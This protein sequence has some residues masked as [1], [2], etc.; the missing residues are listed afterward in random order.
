MQPKAPRRSGR[1]ALLVFVAIIA[2]LFLAVNALTT[3]YIER[4]LA[5]AAEATLARPVSYQSLSANGWT[6]TLSLEELALASVEHATAVGVGSVAADFDPLSLPRDRMRLPRV[7][8]QDVRLDLSRGADGARR[9]ASAFSPGAT[10]PAAP[11]RGLEAGSLRIVGVNL[12]DQY[13]GSEGA[14]L[15]ISEATLEDV[16]VYRAAAV[17]GP[18]YLALASCEIYMASLSILDVEVAPTVDHHIDLVYFDAKR[19]QFPAANAEALWPFKGFGRIG[20]HGRWG[21]LFLTGSLSASPRRVDFEASLHV[22]NLEL[23]PYS[24]YIHPMLDEGK[25]SFMIKLRCRDN[26]LEATL[27]GEAGW[28]WFESIGAQENAKIFGIP[29]RRVQKL[30]FEKHNRL[31]LPEVRITGRLNDP[32]V[33]WPAIIPR[34]LARSMEAEMRELLELPASSRQLT[35]PGLSKAEES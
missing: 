16:Y 33:A 2:V 30:L 31:S 27:S 9:L 7:Q 21:D 14:S 4:D 5:R 25:A 6:G 35:L 3:W 15:S 1:R 23:P 20:A 8:L 19:V 10:A 22:N 34:A 24:P 32:A 28:L 29:E 13:P 17:P 11:W 12:E 26:L 18:A